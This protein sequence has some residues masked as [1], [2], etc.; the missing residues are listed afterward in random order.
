[1]ASKREEESGKEDG[2]QQGH[3]HG[4]HGFLLGVGNGGGEQPDAQ[5]GKQQQPGGDG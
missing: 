1:M 3:P 4:E 2:R 5:P